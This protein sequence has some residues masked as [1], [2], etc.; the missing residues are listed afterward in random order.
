[1][2]LR[3]VSKTRLTVERERVVYNRKTSRKH[4]IELL[5]FLQAKYSNVN[6]TKV[7]TTNILEQ[8]STKDDLYLVFTVAVATF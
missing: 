4:T 8:R 2:R 7:E 5:L 1:M 3:I 6:C